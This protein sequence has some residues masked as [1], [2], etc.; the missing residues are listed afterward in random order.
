[1]IGEGERNFKKK[2]MMNILSCNSSWSNSWGSFV[3]DE[4]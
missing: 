2:E 1:M 3:G 4:R